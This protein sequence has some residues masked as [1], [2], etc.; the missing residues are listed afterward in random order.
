MMTQR[1]IPGDA[2]LMGSTRESFKGEGSR[3]FPNTSSNLFQ[4]KNTLLSME[5][6]LRSRKVGVVVRTVINTSSSSS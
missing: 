4:T 1:S 2:Q 3:S 6:E 5:K